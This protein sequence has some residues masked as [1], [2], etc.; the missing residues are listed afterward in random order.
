MWAAL[1]SVPGFFFFE[2]TGSAQKKAVL[3][4]DLIGGDSGAKLTTLYMYVQ[5]MILNV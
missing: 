5:I 3:A 2:Y 1:G 4:V